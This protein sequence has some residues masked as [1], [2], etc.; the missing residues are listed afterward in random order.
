MR[1]AV[2][3]GVCLFGFS[4]TPLVKSYLNY[5]NKEEP[6]PFL[7]YKDGVVFRPNE[8]PFNRDPN[9]NLLECTFVSNRSIGRWFGNW[10]KLELE[11]EGTRDQWQDFYYKTGHF[12]SN[13]SYKF[14]SFDSF[15]RV[16][17]FGYHKML[18]HDL[19]CLLPDL[20]YRRGPREERDGDCEYYGTIVVDQ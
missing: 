6:N 10:Y 19:L 11:V 14:S 18:S 4:I 2:V 17:V 8:K 15:K 12:D 5:L 13:S 16:R 7:I 20:L 9:T 3:A 1:S